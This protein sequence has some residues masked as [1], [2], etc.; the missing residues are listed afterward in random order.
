MTTSHLKPHVMSSNLHFFTASMQ[1]FIQC[2]HCSLNQMMLL[3]PFSWSICTHRILFKR[4]KKVIIKTGNN[5]VSWAVNQHIRMISEGSCDT[6]DWSNDAENSALHYRNNLHFKIYFNRKQLFLNSN[7]IL[8]YYYLCCVFDWI[9]IALV[10]S[11]KNRQYKSSKY[12]QPQ[13]RKSWDSMEN[14]NKKRK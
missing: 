3:N 8:Q 5:N 9:S 12:I 10:T 1:Q 4:K 13:I 14:A 11:F 7:N 2:D 6:E